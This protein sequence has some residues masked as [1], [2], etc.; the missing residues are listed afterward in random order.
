MGYVPAQYFVEYAYIAQTVGDSSDQAIPYFKYKVIAETN[1]TGVFYQSLPDSGYS[2]DN[3]APEVPDGFNGDLAGGQVNLYWN[4]CPNPDF[5]Y[6]NIY[7][8]V[9]GS[10]SDFVWYANTSDTSY[11]DYDTG[12]DTLNYIITSV[13]F[14]GNESETS[15]ELSFVPTADIVLNLKVYLEGPFIGTD[16]ATILNTE[17]ILP[18]AQP[19][20]IAPWNYTGDESVTAIP[21][22]DIV[23]W[24]LVELRDAIEAQYATG[25]TVI[26]RQAAFLL[27]DGAVVDIDGYSN[28][29]FKETIQNGLFTVIWH[30][31][32]LGTN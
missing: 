24:V 10:E 21:N 2:V 31:N 14:T 7:R 23:D 17:E 6:F 11:T 4:S 25:S 13:D 26:A 27:N 9:A 3:L 15:E 30:R 18:F 16:M 5:S 32:H 22:I 8:Y 20:N 29:Q 1:F 28:L 12:Y 19:Y